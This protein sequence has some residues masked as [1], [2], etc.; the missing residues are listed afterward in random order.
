MKPCKHTYGFHNDKHI[1]VFFTST[2]CVIIQVYISK[3]Y[4]QKIY[5]YI[6]H[7]KENK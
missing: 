6:I 7:L 4:G 3:I 2:D 1:I 5:T